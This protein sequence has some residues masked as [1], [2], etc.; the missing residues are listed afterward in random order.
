MTPP[1]PAH[2]ATKGATRSA[3]VAAAAAGWFRTACLCL[4]ATVLLPLILL[5][6]APVS[7]FGML[8]ASE[9]G[10]FLRC[11]EPVS[12]RLCG[13]APAAAECLDSK[14]AIFADQPTRG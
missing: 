6:C 2:S 11:S 12:R 4:P 1:G 8:A 3:A 5:G 13:D 14:A 10:L 7:A 9:Q